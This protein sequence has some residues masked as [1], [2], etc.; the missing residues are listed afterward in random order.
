MRTPVLAVVEWISMIKSVFGLAESFGPRSSFISRARTCSTIDLLGSAKS[1]REK[2]LIL[3]NRYS[4]S[5][6]NSYSY[7]E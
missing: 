1:A 4:N 7:N 5:N 2:H 3:G 6:S